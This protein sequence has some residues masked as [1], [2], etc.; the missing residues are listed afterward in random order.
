MKVKLTKINTTMNNTPKT[1]KELVRDIH[2]DT[3]HLADSVMYFLKVREEAKPP[4]P[5]AESKK[6]WEEMHFLLRRFRSW[7]EY[8]PESQ[9]PKDLIKEA[10]EFLKE[11]A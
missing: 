4:D 5:Q 11:K 1:L 2:L 8:L 6:R 7:A 10:N 9:K 3:Y